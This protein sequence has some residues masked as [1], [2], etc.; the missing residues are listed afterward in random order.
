MIGDERNMRNYLSK[1]PDCNIRE[2]CLK[3]FKITGYLLTQQNNV[4]FDY[5]IKRFQTDLTLKAY[6][7]C[8][9]LDSRNIAYNIS[10][11]YDKSKPLAWNIKKLK[12]YFRL[13]YRLK[14][15]R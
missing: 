10:F 6:D 11:I 13:I 5:I 8:H 12:S 15:E 4:D 3:S 2:C 9:W 7:V 1:E 14:V